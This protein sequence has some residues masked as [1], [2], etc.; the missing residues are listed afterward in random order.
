MSLL[1]GFSGQSCQHEKMFDILK[2]NEKGKKW[3]S[4]ASDI[5]HKNLFDEK[6]ILENKDDFF[7]AQI[8]I[9]LL[10]IGVFHLIDSLLPNIDFILCGYSLGETSAFCA[11]AHLDM[12]QIYSLIEARARYMQEAVFKYTGNQSCGLAALKGRLNEKIVQELTTTYQCYIAIINDEDHYIVGG[13]KTQLEKLLAEAKQRGITKAE[14]INVH[15]PSH[16]PMLQEATQNF[17]NYLKKF[18]DC[19]LQYPILNALSTEQIF[20]S[21]EMTS[22]LSNELSQ[23]LHWKKVMQIAQEYQITAFLELGPKNSLKNIAA[24][25][26]AETYALEDFSSIEGII[27]YIHKKFSNNLGS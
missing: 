22:I 25:Y 6:I 14:F 12:Q 23:T 7:Y 1:I 10:S 3:L 15:L 2:K 21:Q 18:Q 27:N 11:S 5:L 4:E 17:N 19:S 16:T 24:N 9:A 26:F 13:L 8:F 20:T